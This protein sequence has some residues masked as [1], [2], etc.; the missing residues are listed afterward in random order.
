VKQPMTIATF[1]FYL[2]EKIVRFCSYY[3]WDRLHKVWG[4]C[5]TAWWGSISR[6]SRGARL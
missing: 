2:T 4:G 5:A 6:G 3:A 1:A